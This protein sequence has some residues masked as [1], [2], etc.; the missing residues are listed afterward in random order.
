MFA[1]RALTSKAILTQAY[2]HDSTVI[3]DLG[4]HLPLVA[5]LL[6]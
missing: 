5:D 6:I 2:V 4:D 3:Q 1:S